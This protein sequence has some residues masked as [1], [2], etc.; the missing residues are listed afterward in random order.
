MALDNRY[1]YWRLQ[2]Q[3]KAMS[4]MIHNIDREIWND[5][6]TRSTTA[7]LALMDAQTAMNGIAI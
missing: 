5:L 3:K 2:P 7:M 4:I 6:M 1:E